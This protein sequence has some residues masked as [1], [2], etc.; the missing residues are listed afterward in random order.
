MPR[1]RSPGWMFNARSIH[2][3]IR[4][5]SSLATAA[6]VLRAAVAVQTPP[7]AGESAGLF[8]NLGAFSTPAGAAAAALSERRHSGVD[9]YYL[10]VHI[11]GG[12]F[13]IAADFQG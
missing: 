10:L 9:K 1:P 11:L 3:F 2:L 8:R 6:I 4:Q 13:A 5:Y 7:T 12:E